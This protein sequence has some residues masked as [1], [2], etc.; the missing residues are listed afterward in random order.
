M[1]LAGTAD[2]AG[3]VVVAGGATIPRMALGT[4]RL[5]GDVLSA[6][7]EAAIGCGYRHIDTAA[8]YGN[9]A[10]VGEAIASFPRSSLF[11][12]TKA[13]PRSRPSDFLADVESGLGRLR[14]GYVDLLLIHWPD[15]AAPLAG[16]IGPL[17]DARRRGLARHV[18]VSNFPPRFLERATDIASEPLVVNQVER[19]PYLDQS[20]L[21]QTCAA[22]DVALMA[23]CPLGR[24]ALMDEPVVAEIARSHGRTPAQV[25]LRWNLERPM[26][27]VAPKSTRP[28]RV[29]E[30]FGALDFTLSEDECARLSALA[31][32]DGRVVRGPEGFDW[33]GVPV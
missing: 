18:G 2:D 17:C 5:R 25:V 28:E 32:S 23:F 26:T 31:R 16:Q 3:P 13:L 22:L 30:N 1:S 24:G 15:S 20:A 8:K 7:V 11:I 19:H 4:G 27:I 10:D 6:A 14:L 33:N 12:T 9:E 21:E 29:V